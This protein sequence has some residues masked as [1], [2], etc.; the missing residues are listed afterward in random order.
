MT[1]AKPSSNRSHHC[2]GRQFPPVDEDEFAASLLDALRR[3]GPSLQSLTAVTS[4][5]RAYRDE[6]ARRVID[7][8]DPHKAGWTFLVANDDPRKAEI[9]EAVKPLALYRGMTNP[10]APLSFASDAQEDWVDWVQNNLLSRALDGE[11]V[12]QYILMVGSP[13]LLPFKLQSLLDTFARKHSAL[14]V[15]CDLSGDGAGFVAHRKMARRTVSGSA[16]GQAGTGLGGSQG[17][18]R[19]ASWR[20]CIALCPCL[21]AVDR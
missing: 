7:A 16:W 9:I 4:S 19:I 17:R 12:P 6:V 15:S 11:Q 18:P 13:R 20:A 8:G 1:V 21:I 10:S 5:T 2:G 3:N 14:A